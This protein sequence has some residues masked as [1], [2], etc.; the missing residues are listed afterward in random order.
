MDYASM[1]G[2]VFEFMEGERI[3]SAVLLGHSM[4][5]KV[6]MRLAQLSP[7]RVATLIVVDIAPRKY[8]NRTCTLWGQGE[9]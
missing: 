5:G 4:G 2:D 1:A 7:A 9:D 6:A 8:Q 3:E